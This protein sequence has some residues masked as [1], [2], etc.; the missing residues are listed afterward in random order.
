MAEKSNMMMKVIIGIVIVVV[1]V[2]IFRG[3][4]NREMPSAPA[5]GP[6]GEP[7]APS[8]APEPGTSTAPPAIPAEPAK[9]PAEVVFSKG[10]TLVDNI[11][12]NYATSTVTFRFTNTEEKTLK[13]HTGELV[14]LTPNSEFNY[15]RLAV[16]GR[17][18]NPNWGRTIS[19]DKYEIDPGATVTCTM[20]GVVL[21]HSDQG[22]ELTG[23]R[24][25]NVLTA[26]NMNSAFRNYNDLDYF[27]CE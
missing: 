23:M 9:T 19:C 11:N 12:C 10:L 13:I 24:G 4:S 21:R 27:V 8:A 6:G 26:S 2:L 25:Q 20:G 22:S 15:V 14:Q 1:L 3:M 7:S 18:A 17:W 16:N 5:P